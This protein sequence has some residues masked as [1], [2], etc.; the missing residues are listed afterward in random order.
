MLLDVIVPTKNN[1][2]TLENCLR[3]L[4]NQIIQVGIIVVDGYS[5]DNTR[6]IASKYTKH[7][8]FEPKTN[9]KGSKR[10][11]ACN[12]GLRRSKSLFIGF[13]DSDVEVPQ[14]WAEKLLKALRNDLVVI[15]VTSGC[16]GWDGEKNG[17]SYAVSRV[18]TIGSDSHGKQFKKK[19]NIK[20]IQGYNAIYRREHLDD[21]GGFNEEIGGCED[22]ELNYRLRKAGWKLIGIPEAPVKHRHKVSPKSFAK[23]MYGYGWSRGRLLKIRHIFTL[24]HMLPSLALISLIIFGILYPPT[25][26][27]FLTSV[28]RSPQS[29]FEKVIEVYL[30]LIGL[31]SFTLIS[32]E[33]A[34]KLWF[35]VFGA[36]IIQHL[37]WAVGY[38]HGFLF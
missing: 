22:W 3:S 20:S 5:T 14:D 37:S 13:I 31:L 1:E 23:Q 18:M 4:S 33:F 12:E 25:T 36:F 7:V 16:G 2:K 38:L 34:P 19:R 30:F 32:K 11:V 15:G 8:Y 24:T 29:W 17:F 27:S 9:S 28:F 6:L 35:Q 21:V 10:A 26:F